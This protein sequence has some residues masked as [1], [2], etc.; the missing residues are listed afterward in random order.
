MAALIKALDSHTPVQ[1][2]SL[3]EGI[4]SQQPATRVDGCLQTGENGHTEFAWS[5]DIQEKI[6]Q[7]EFQ[8][9][10]TDSN[11]IDELSEILC[12]LLRRLSKPQSSPALEEKRKEHLIILYKLIGKTR[13][14]NGGKGEYTLS[15]MMIWK[16]YQYFP[17][18]SIFALRLFVHSPAIEYRAAAIEDGDRADEDEPYGSWKDIKYMCKYLQ[19]YPGCSM[20]HPLMQ[21]CINLINNQLRED[22]RLYQE[23]DVENNKNIQ[24]SLAAKWVTRETSSKFGFIYSKLSANYFPEYM[25]TAKKPSSIIRAQK[26]CN[27]QYRLLCATLNRHLDT[28]QIKQCSGNWASIDHAKTT[29]IT[30]AKQRKALLNLSLKEDDQTG[31]PVQR[32]DNIDRIKCA[33]NLKAHMKSLVKAGKEVKG[34][35][36]GLNT[37]TFDANRLLYQTNVDQTELDILNSQWR[38]N[39]NQKN[40]KGLGP[41]VAMVDKSGSMSGDPENAATALGIRIAEK[42]ILGKRVMT[43]NSDPKWIDLDGCNT[44][45]EMVQKINCS[46]RDAG[47]CTNFYAALDLMLTAIEESCIL[48]EEVENMIL[49]ILSDMQIDV[50]L[51]GGEPGVTYAQMEAGKKNWNTMYLVIKQKYHDV[52]MRLYGKPLMPPHILFW[53]FRHTGGFP[54]LS[55]QGNTSMMSGFDPTIL[56]MFCEMGMDAL[57]GL[58]PFNCLVRSL[59]NVRYTPLEIAMRTYL[60]Q[61]Q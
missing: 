6:C 3:A 35:H 29:S 11:G 52:G 56:N 26:K 51:G 5:N 38:D 30:I 15:Y 27:I 60:D 34:K 23:H 57:R 20:A 45:T 7:F 22:F 54:V 41:M 50:N 46:N 18:M 48:P 47:Y 55:S 17:E 25:A 43:F 39:A 24:I 33:E 16:W 2:P 13:D 31:K 21:N 53:N 36:V 4:P 9:V 32:S 40:A 10:R 14:I 49:V 19:V 1:N 58:T 28:I 37:F 42:S 12:N 61:Y 8:C 44:F 59:D